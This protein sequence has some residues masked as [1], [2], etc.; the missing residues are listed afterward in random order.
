MNDGEESEDPFDS[1]EANFVFNW[2]GYPDNAMM[3]VESPERMNFL[4]PSDYRKK[5]AEELASRLLTQSPEPIDAEGLKKL[6]IISEEDLVAKVR[7][8]VISIA[9]LA[10]VICPVQRMFG[11]RACDLT[12][13]E[14]PEVE[15][16]SRKRT[17]KPSREY[18]IKRQYEQQQEL[19]RQQQ[20]SST[21]S[22]IPLQQMLLQQQM[23]GQAM[24][25]SRMGYGNMFG[26][27]P[28]ST[29]GPPPSSH[30]SI[31]GYPRERATMPNELSSSASSSS[32][33]LNPGLPPPGS[34][35]DPQLFYLMMQHNMRHPNMP[36]M[37]EQ[38]RSRHLQADMHQ[39]NMASINRPPQI[40]VPYMDEHEQPSTTPHQAAY[41]N[42]QTSNH[43]QMLLLPSRKSPPSPET[44]N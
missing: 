17:R 7:K 30:N 19:Q 37:N 6:G 39:G 8:E 28:M 23:F 44:K 9:K 35:F 36:P 24:M 16:R 27:L 12:F 22:N 43:N 2:L 11:K 42:K 41:Q 29:L 33:A 5:R 26:A 18:L 40:D 21:T 4:C 13:D 20:P 25:A 1:E 31:L 14:L 10:A 15:V 32:P 3:E 34:A 38:L